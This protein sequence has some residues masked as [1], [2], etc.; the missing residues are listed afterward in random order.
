MSTFSMGSEELSLFKTE[1]QKNGFLVKDGF[2]SASQCQEY[3]RTIEQFREH[4]VLEEIHRE[5]K[6][7]P[8]HYFVIDGYQI[9]GEVTE[10]FELHQALLPVVSELCGEQMV[11]LQNKKASINVNI[12]PKGGSYRWHYDRNAV[13]VLVYL[14]DVEGG[15]IEFYPNY[16]LYLKGK[17]PTWLQ[18]WL[19]SL[20]ALDFVRRLF[21]RHVIVHP[22]AGR[23]VVIQGVRCLHS[24]RAVTSDQERI[25][26][27]SSYDTPDAHLANNKELDTYLYTQRKTATDPNYSHAGAQ[28]KA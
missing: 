20:L 14:N 9:E 19:D 26:I 7:R 16:R 23:M 15:E 22:Q 4:S 21:G 13:T 6:G 10:I 27:V 1:Y 28:E 17:G 24:V 12:T 3:L 18:R 8:L 11:P 25:N 2:L 5:V